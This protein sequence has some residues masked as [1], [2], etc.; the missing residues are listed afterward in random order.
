MEVVIMYH[1]LKADPDLRHL[2]H[3]A[4]LGRTS[5]HCTEISSK[6]DH[7]SSVLQRQEILITEC[8]DISGLVTQLNLTQYVHRI[9]VDVY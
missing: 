5:G 7:L 4:P 1:F 8:S 3:M 9:E 2:N 6:C